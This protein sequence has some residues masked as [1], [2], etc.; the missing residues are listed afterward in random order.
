MF[1]GKPL[2]LQVKHI[3]IL[4]LVCAAILVLLVQMLLVVCSD[5]QE[6]EKH[7]NNETESMPRRNCIIKIDHKRELPYSYI[8]SSVTIF[9]VIIDIP[10]SVVLL[11]GTRKKLRNHILPWLVINAFK[12]ILIIVAICIIVWCTYVHVEGGIQF[13]YGMTPNGGGLKRSLQYQWR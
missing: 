7:V 9:L 1:W 12:M 8:A 3:G 13:Y 2:Q 6:V 5:S 10:S 4:T 11:V